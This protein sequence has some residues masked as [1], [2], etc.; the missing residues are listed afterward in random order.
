MLIPE[1]RKNLPFFYTMK[2]STTVMRTHIFIPDIGSEPRRK[3]YSLL[4][5]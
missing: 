1:L 3:M 4:S 2:L 5:R